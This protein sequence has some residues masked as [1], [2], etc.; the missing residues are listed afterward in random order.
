MNTVTGAELR[1][2]IPPAATLAPRREVP[3]RAESGASNMLGMM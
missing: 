2:T 1:M 3:Q